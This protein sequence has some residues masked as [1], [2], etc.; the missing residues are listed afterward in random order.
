MVAAFIGR[1]AASHPS[2]PTVPVCGFVDATPPQPERGDALDWRSRSLG[3]TTVMVIRGETASYRV[4]LSSRSFPPELRSVPEVR[5]AVTDFLGDRLEPNVAET[6]K[7]LSTELAANAVNHAGTDF[8]VA[9]E[10][11]GGVLRVAVTDGENRRPVRAIPEPTDT[12]GRGVLLMDAYSSC[13]GV[14]P[15]PN[16]KRVWFELHDC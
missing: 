8:T 1:R 7:L 9:A 3:T 13:W 12:G 6:A 11:E 5:Q 10:L 16:G 15:L 2:L 4:E 14:E